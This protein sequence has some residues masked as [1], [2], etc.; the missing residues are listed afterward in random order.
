MLLRKQVSVRNGEKKLVV[1]KESR[2]Y[3]PTVNVQMIVCCLRLT[4][5]LTEWV[6]EEGTKFAHYMDVLSAI[7]GLQKSFTGLS[8][9]N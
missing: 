2:K 8:N 4:S 5:D 3:Y 9:K 1:K 7:Q 6:K